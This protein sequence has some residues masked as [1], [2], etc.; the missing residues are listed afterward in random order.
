MNKSELSDKIK[1]IEAA[2]RELTKAITDLVGENPGGLI[3]AHAFASQMHLQDALNRV[4]NIT[5][6][7]AQKTNESVESA[8][9]EAVET[10]KIRV[11]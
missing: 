5:M 10:S 7:L 9:D 1:R 3:G 6:V 8:V 4:S 11:M 2:A